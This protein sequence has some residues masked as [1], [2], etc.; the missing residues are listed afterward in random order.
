MGGR[1]EAGL[2]KYQL[3]KNSYS[4]WMWKKIVTEVRS[5]PQR[6]NEQ[7]QKKIPTEFSARKKKYCVPKFTHPPLSSKI[8]WSYPKDGKL[9]QLY[10]KKGRTNVHD[11]VEMGLKDVEYCSFN[12]STDNV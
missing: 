9:I 6:K 7:V 4:A 12:N 8:Q 1:K 11:S 3:K 2:G 10:H 5:K